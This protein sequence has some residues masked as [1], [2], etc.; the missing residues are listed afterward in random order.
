MAGVDPKDDS[1]TPPRRYD[2]ANPT[3]DLYGT[4]AYPG[5]DGVDVW[6][7][8]TGQ[9]EQPPRLLVLTAEVVMNGSTKLLTSSVAIDSENDGWREPNGTWVAPSPEWRC[10]LS[11]AR[12]P[13]PCLFDVERD[14]RE[15]V[16]LACANSP[17]SG[18]AVGKMK[19][20]RAAQ[21]AAA[22]GTVAHARTPQCHAGCRIPQPA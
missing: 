12:N 2:P 19:R 21:A 3:R 1:P 10:G 18:R 7:W 15:Q 11:H 9:A 6:P 4:D 22:G 14:P 8:L 16:D 5:V 20:M 17:S 13:P